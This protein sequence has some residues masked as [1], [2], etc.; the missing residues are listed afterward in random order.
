MFPLSHLIPYF[1]IPLFLYTYPGPTAAILF[2]IV[3]IKIDIDAMPNP[4]GRPP[5]GSKRKAQSLTNSSRASKRSS[6]TTKASTE[7]STTSPHPT[8][9]HVPFP[10][11]V[12]TGEVHL[13]DIVLNNDATVTCDYAFKGIGNTATYMHLGSTFGE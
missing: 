5:K 7:I 4:V 13:T 12:T 9:A 11:D 8:E 6:T 1:W 3:L 2:V 10:A